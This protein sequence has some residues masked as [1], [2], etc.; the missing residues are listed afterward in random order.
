MKACWI[1]KHFVFELP[2]IHEGCFEYRFRGEGQWG[3]KPNFQ[4]FKLLY[5]SLRLLN[6]E[7]CTI[8][9]VIFI[10][11][12]PNCL[13]KPLTLMSFASPHKL[14]CCTDI[15]MVSVLHGNNLGI[16]K[17]LLCLSTFE[18]KCLFVDSVYTDFFLI[19]RYTS[20]IIY[21]YMG[22]FA[23][24]GLNGFK[25]GQTHFSPDLLKAHKCTN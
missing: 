20:G 16:W 23:Q 11:S 18:R 6:F 9:I 8:S 10:C 1:F 7:I 14:N 2:Q 15:Y 17:L 5:P 4:A 24:F 25:H 19:R 12:K 21:V 3:Q 13:I 22:Q